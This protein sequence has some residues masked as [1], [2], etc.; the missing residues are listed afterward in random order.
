MDLPVWVILDDGPAAGHVEEKPYGL[1]ELTVK[2][3]RDGVCIYRLVQYRPP[4]VAHYRFCKSL[5][6]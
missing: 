1:R 4:G 3:N 6:I 5:V 2:T